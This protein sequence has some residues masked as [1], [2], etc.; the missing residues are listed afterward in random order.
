MSLKSLL[1]PLGFVILFVTNCDLSPLEDTELYPAS[2]PEL[3][4]DEL[5]S[6]N[7]EF[8]AKN[9]GKI[10]STLNEYGLTGF[11]RV[12]F[13]NDTNPCL[14]RTEVK[15]EIQ[16][17]E[18]LLNQAKVALSTNQEYTNV[19]DPQSLSLKESFPLYGCTICEGPN[20]N[21]VPLQWRFSF[22]NQVKDGTEVLET[23]I[24]VYVDANGV[25]RIWG[26]WYHIY[27]PKFIEVGYIYAQELFLGKSLT[28]EDSSGVLVQHK[29]IANDFGKPPYLKFLPI[30]KEGMLELRKCWVVEL[31]IDSILKWKGMV[32]VQTGEILQIETI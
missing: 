5:V 32:D 27:E 17:S 8:Q 1:Y 2:I 13:I 23:E 25:N 18:N 6:M 9:D 7:M 19:V 12:L 30:K 10:C 24:S 15:I 21:S 20:I 14:D 22:E 26:N 11:S 31:M 3:G 4:M 28:Y 29:I 16:Y